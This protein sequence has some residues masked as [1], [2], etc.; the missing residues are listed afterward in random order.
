VVWDILHISSSDC[1]GPGADNGLCPLSSAPPVSWCQ[2]IISLVLWGQTMD[3]FEDR[4]GHLKVKVLSLRNEWNIILMIQVRSEL[5]S[6][7]DT[8]I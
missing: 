6:P 2:R 1:K 5:I 7:Q 4:H 8:S 3:T